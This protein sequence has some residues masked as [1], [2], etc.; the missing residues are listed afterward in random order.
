MEGL[1]PSQIA[2]RIDVPRSTIKN[3]VVDLPKHSTGF[4]QRPHGTAA[5]RV[6]RLTGREGE[7]IR[8]EMQA[9]DK[10]ACF[11]CESDVY[12]ER[13]WFARVFHHYDDGTVDSAHAAC[14]AVRRHQVI[15]KA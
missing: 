12:D 13:G 4:S 14:N 11:F 5:A 3:W 7:A 15:T 2:E 10:G 9:K 1:T 6:A 8:L